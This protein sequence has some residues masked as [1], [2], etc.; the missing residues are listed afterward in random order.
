MATLEERVNEA[1]FEIGTDVKALLGATGGAI[2]LDGLTDVVIAGLATGDLLRYNGTNFVNAQPVAAS[3]TQA[4]V[5]ENA[6]D[7]ETITGT[8]VNRTVT[9]AN[10]AARIVALIATSTSLGTSDTVVPSQAAVKAYVDAL[11]AAANAMVFKG[12]IDAS[13]NPNYPAA[14]AGDVYRISV[15]GKIG[16]ASGPNVE[17]GDQLL[18]LTD[19]LAAGNHATVGASWNITQVNVDGVVVGPASSTDGDIVAFSGTSGKVVQTVGSTSYGRA[20]L[21]LANTAALMGL[22]SAASETVAGIAE[23]ATSAE[24]T[25]ATDDARIVTPLKLQTRLT[26]LL[27]DTDNSFLTTYTTARDS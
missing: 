2:D 27:G 19:G 14:S 18:A 5:Q 22:I 8:A 26:A 12:T 20:F 23:L 9:P 16:G 3:D 7:A 24:V 13:A 4:G 17:I 6:T 1:M 25:T 21:A 10:L 11:L 15:A